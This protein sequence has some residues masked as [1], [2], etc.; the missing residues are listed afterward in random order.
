MSEMFLPFA[1]SL[2]DAALGL[3][4]SPGKAGFIRTITPFPVLIQSSSPGHLQI[5][6]V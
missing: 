6:H 1:E 5:G 3:L 2:D 4:C